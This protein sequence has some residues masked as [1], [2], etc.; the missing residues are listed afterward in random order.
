VTAGRK[1]DSARG[2]PVA[3]PPAVTRG[4]EHRIA[5]LALAG[6]LFAGGLIGSFNLTLDGVV[7]DGA[8]R[9][10]YAATMGLCMLTSVPLLLRER[11]GKK[12]TFALV[13]LGD[14]VYVVVALCLRDPTHYATPL[15]LL[16]PVF[17]AAWFLGPVQLGVNMLVT[18]GAVFAGLWHNYPTG[19][20]LAIQTV[21][22]AGMLNL[23]ALG[24]FVLRRRIERLLAATQALSSTDPLTGLWNRRFLVEQAP[25]VWRQARRDGNRV[26]AMVLDLDHFKRLNDAHGHAAGDAVL[27]AVADALRGTVRPAD[28]LARTGGEELVVL[29]LV[30][31]AA[32]AHHL[33]ERLRAAVSASCTDDGHRV[34][35]SIGLALC[36]PGDGEDPA[37]ALWKLIDRADAAMYDAKKQGRDRV[38]AVLVPRPRS[39]RVAEQSL[40]PAAEL[41][42]PSEDLPP[43]HVPHPDSPA[44]DVA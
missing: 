3:A 20:D 1:T 40:P 8:P 18:A 41:P 5:A 43:A 7:R 19:T 26:A 22:N 30:G 11:A 2:I 33:A 39:A 13:L 42:R 36:R 44:S 21:V 16:F 6:L 29:G 15:M 31:D 38:A 37:D 4:A 10:I 9:A 35:A 25:R 17:V 28:V 23:T 12:Q 34:T 24:V 27:C 14:L 32:E